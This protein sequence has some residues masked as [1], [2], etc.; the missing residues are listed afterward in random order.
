MGYFTTEGRTN[1]WKYFLQILLPAILGGFGGK[2]MGSGNPEEFAIGFFLA[3]LANILALFPAV[4]R[5][6]DINASGWW[7]ILSL[8]PV[9][10]FVLGVVLL[11]VK[12]TEGE[13]RYGPDPLQTEVTDEQST[14]A[15]RDTGRLSPSTGKA[16]KVG[17]EDTREFNPDEHE[18]KCPMCAEYIKL[19]A[20]R[21]KHCGHEY[22][23]EKV[24]RQ[25]EK[26]KHEV[27]QER[28]EQAPTPEPGDKNRNICPNCYTHHAPQVEE[29]SRCGMSLTD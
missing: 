25:I 16:K 17:A 2:V 8:V 7:F 13:N 18:K 14:S 1:R 24:E 27:K 20:R 11:F 26:L 9:A 3:I 15:N 5:L 21:C 12:G 29:C 4:R 19:E 6:H 10:N 28:E 22:S 23:V